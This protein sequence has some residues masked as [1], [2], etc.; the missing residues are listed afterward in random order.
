MGRSELLLVL[1]ALTIF[2]RFSLVVNNSLIDSST[3]VLEN[4]FEITGITL[5]QEII[6]EV[7]SMAFDETSIGT[8]P[9]TIPGGFT[10]SASLGPDGGETD[11]S[12]FDDIDDYHGLTITGITSAGMNYNITTEIGYVSEADLVTLSTTISALKRMNLTLTSD[13]LSNDLSLS[14]VYSYIRI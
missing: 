3:R 4:E 2:G 13:Y 5:L 14:Y 1:A 6:S 10:A 7:G 12:M 8:I 9:P 11:S